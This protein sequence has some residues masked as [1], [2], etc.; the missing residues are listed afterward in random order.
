M[1]EV[2]TARRDLTI[3]LGVL[4]AVLGSGEANAQA[5]SLLRP[6][7]RVRLFV[8]TFE[9]PRLVAGTLLW[10]SRDSVTIVPRSGVFPRSFAL[11]NLVRFQVNR[12]RPRALLYG[13]PLYGA[14]LGAWFGATALAADP[15]CRAGA[16]DAGCRWE[17]SATI[18]G[19]AGGA[20]LFAMAVQL[21]VPEV[22]RDVPLTA[23]GGAPGGSGGAGMSIGLM[24]RLR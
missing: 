19:A 22:W 2:Q 15:A 23:F 8:K 18:V 24:L 21:L 7:A 6:D 20:V 17:T 4:C 11:E 12:G 10:F 16:T 13:A 9:E 1:P 14:L 3:F 5:R